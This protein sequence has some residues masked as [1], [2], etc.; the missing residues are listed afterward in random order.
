MTQ[1]AAPEIQYVPHKLINGLD[2]NY[3]VLAV[4]HL[5]ESSTMTSHPRPVERE[6]TR[7]HEVDEN[8]PHISG[9]GANIVQSPK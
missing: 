3:E 1:A 5:D 2:V 8:S 9:R 7:R 4:V 6:D